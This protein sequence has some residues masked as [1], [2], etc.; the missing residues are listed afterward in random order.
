MRK[1]IHVTLPNIIDTEIEKKKKRIYTNFEIDLF[2]D[3]IQ[4]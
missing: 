3:L 1:D 4:K 2:L